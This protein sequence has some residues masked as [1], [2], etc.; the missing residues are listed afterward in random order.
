[1]LLLGMFAAINVQI[2]CR[3]LCRCVNVDLHGGVPL[4]TMQQSKRVFG[5]YIWRN[6]GSVCI[7]DAPWQ[8]RGWMGGSQGIEGMGSRWGSANIWSGLPSLLLFYTFFGGWFT[9]FII[10]PGGDRV[11]GSG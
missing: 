11:A 4:A 10:D 1:M 8:S 2:C 3:L 6:Q 5:L 9:L 7:V